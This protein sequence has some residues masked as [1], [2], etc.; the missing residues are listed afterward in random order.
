MTFTIAQAWLLF[1]Q[2][3]PIAAMVYTFVATRRKD[4]DRRFKEGSER[5][6]RMDQRISKLEHSVGGLPSREDIHSI[7]INIER[8][9]GTMSRMEAV[10]EGNTKIMSRLEQIVSRHEDHLLKGN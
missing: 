1:L 10:M 4:Y 5:M 3:L 2:V 6:D 9:G 7:Q 8:L